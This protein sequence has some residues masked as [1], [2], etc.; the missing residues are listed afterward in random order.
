MNVNGPCWGYEFT[1]ARSITVDNTKAVLIEY[2]ATLENKERMIKKY[3][4][5]MAI[6]T[7]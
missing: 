1:S 4:F 3:S 2:H 7:G 5:Q 6:I